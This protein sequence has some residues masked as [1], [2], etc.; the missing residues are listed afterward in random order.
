MIDFLNYLNC[1]E[2]VFQNYYYCECS[3]LLSFDQF[4]CIDKMI[5]SG[6]NEGSLNFCGLFW[7]SY[8]FSLHSAMLCPYLRQ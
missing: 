7:L 8:C 2:V 6:Q 4:S 3:Y 5:C 1:L